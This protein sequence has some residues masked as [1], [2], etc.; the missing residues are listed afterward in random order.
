VEALV[1]MSIMSVG[2]LGMSASA[3][4]LSRTAKWADM[5]S[6]ATAL[7]TERL[8]LVRSLPLGDAGHTTG[9]YNAGTMQADGTANGP[10]T[11]AW[12]VSAKDTPWVGLKTVTVT[13]S[14]NQYN[15]ART[16]QMGALVRCTKTPC[17]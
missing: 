2:V 17:P 4:E 10:Y 13:T 5:A 1:T 16:V 7:A 9:S 6:A 3:I 14:W 8:E 12:V 15:K 11:V